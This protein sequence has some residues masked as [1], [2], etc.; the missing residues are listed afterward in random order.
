MI[1][2]TTC[3]KVS[4]VSRASR[5]SCCSVF[6]HELLASVKGPLTEPAVVQFQLSPSIYDFV[7]GRVPEIFVMS[8]VGNTARVKDLFL[9]APLS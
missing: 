8:N 4:P 7:G 5:V 3:G 2:K 1:L 9:D 6:S